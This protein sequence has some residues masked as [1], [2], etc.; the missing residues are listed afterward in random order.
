MV[1]AIRHTEKF[2]RHHRYS[3]GIAI[4]NRLQKILELLLRAKYSHDKKGFLGG[5]NIEL[6]ILR[7]FEPH[8]EIFFCD[9]FSF[10]GA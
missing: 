9:L 2:P 1:W 7:T 3:L 4:E 8:F 10:G 5:A 6:E